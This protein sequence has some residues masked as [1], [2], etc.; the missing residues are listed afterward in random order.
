M[1]LKRSMMHRVI[2]HPSRTAHSCSITTLD[3]FVVW[4]V[5]ALSLPA[6]NPALGQS[7]TY[8]LGTTNLL[9]GPTAGIDSVVLGV[10]P[11]SG[12]WAAEANTNWLHL[13]SANQTGTG[14]TNVIFTYDANPGAAR[15]G[16]L[17]IAGQAVTVTQAGSSYIAAQTLTF[18][19]SSG[20]A[21]PYGMAVDRVGNVYVACA[22]DGGAIKKWS[23]NANTLTTLVSNGL[24]S[25]FGLAL[26]AA[27]NVYI[28]DSGNNALKEWIAASSNVITLSPTLDRPLAVAVDLQSNVYVEENLTDIVERNAATGNVTT[29]VSNLYGANGVAVDVAGNVY[30]SYDGAVG[31]WSVANTN[32]TI[33][34]TQS[35]FSP[36]TVSVDGAGN[37]YI[38]GYDAIQEWR[39]AD[40]T[41][42]TL[43]STESSVLLDSSEFTHFYGVTVDSAGNIFAADNI[44]FAIMELPY[45][46]VD[47]APKVESAAAGTDSLSPVEPP[48]ENLLPPFA[49]TSD[50]PW[51]NIT[52][53]TNGVVSFSVSANS[54]PPRIGFINVLGQAIPVIQVSLGPPINLTTVPTD[55]S[56]TVNFVFGSSTNL[57]FTVFSSTNVSVPI[58]SWTAIGTASNIAPTVFEFTDTNA[59]SD[60]QR[61]YRVGYP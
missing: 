48:T 42:L 49:P 32:V 11:V 19:D 10:S 61:F 18:L 7:P 8:V 43:V 13:S 51:L 1:F 39:V 37:L 54:G 44:N 33:M 36:G 5:I 40:N 41:L 34:P 26:D 55:G 6:L 9:V 2:K 20:L 3:R 30:F 58:T 35:R 4:A 60:S 59:A 28:A 57:S 52:G 27:G 31:K 47:M 38:G 23:P 46:F 50:Q 56:A 25:P 22:G 15:S 16:T 21:V 12:N 17:N 53:V 29:L 14:S 24:D 45:A